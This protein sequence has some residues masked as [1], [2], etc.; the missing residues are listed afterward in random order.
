[1]LFLQSWWSN[2]YKRPL[3]DPL[4]QQ[5]TLAELLYEFYNKKER[6]KAQDNIAEKNDDKIEDERLKANLTWAEAEEKKELERLQKL[7]VDNV[8]KKT[9]EKIISDPDNQQ[10]MK[11]QIDKELKTGKKIHGDDFGE[12]LDIDAPNYDIKEDNDV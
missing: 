4:L 9:A 3:K 7:K 8:D 11:D 2:E 6:Q 10:W 12:D 5:Y 1:M